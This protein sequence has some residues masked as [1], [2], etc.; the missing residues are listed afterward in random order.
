[1]VVV[2]IAALLA[3]KNSPD[4]SEAQ[5]ADVFLHNI[6]AVVKVRGGGAARAAERQAEGSGVSRSERAIP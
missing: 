4:S 3:V 6:V 2:E 1:M 5:P